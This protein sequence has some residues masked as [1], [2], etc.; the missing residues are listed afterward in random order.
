MEAKLDRPEPVAPTVN[1]ECLVEEVSRLRPENIL[2]ESGDY[3]VLLVKADDIPRLLYEVGRLREVTFRSVGEGT[4]ERID[5]D[6]FDSFYAHLI[7]WNRSRSEVVGAYRMGQT[8][9]IL[10]RYGIDGLYTSTLFDYRMEL[11]ARI[12]PALELGRSFVRP[13]Y[14][15]SY[16]ALSL[17]WTGIA[18]FV[19]RHPYYKILFGAVSIS[20][21]YNPLSQQLIVDHLWKSHHFSSLVRFVR[22]R[23]PVD[24]R[25]SSSGD[26]VSNGSLSEVAE[27]VSS[28]EGGRKGIPI[29]VRQYVKLG[30]KVLAFSRDPSFG[31]TLDGLMLVD[32]CQAPRRVL[33]RFMGT[34]EL[35]AFLEHHERAVRWRERIELPAA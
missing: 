13:E 31:D 25:P 1:P 21:D 30:G 3:R 19:A 15:R 2:V 4:G 24:A 7:L 23:N 32:L 26:R 29:L 33:G 11:L 16:S 9:E 20:N 5:L 18:R 10:P 6:W 28:L 12:T 8:D 35:A 14:Q 22:G 34:P 17:L 27:R